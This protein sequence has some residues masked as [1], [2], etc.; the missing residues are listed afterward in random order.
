[1]ETWEQLIL[2]RVVRR[3]PLVD[4]SRVGRVRQVSD[5]LLKRVDCMFS[6]GGVRDSFTV[7]VRLVANLT[8]DG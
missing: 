3:D 4:A 6:T 2:E 1:M 5:P 7:L 8:R